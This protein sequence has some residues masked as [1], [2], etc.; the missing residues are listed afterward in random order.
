MDITDPALQAAM[1]GGQSPTQGSDYGLP[2]VRATCSGSCPQ[3]TYAV[4]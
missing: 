4:R 2:P 1:G 3:A